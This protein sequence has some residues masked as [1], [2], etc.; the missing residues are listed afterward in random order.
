MNKENRYI[1]E[2]EEDEYWYNE[3]ENQKI[4]EEQ[5]WKKKKRKRL[6]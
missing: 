6:R 1:K 3:W 4:Y 5:E 2:W